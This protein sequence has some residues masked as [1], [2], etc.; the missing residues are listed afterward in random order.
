MPLRNSL[1]FQVR[2]WR[3][4]LKKKWRIVNWIC[5]C[6]PAFFL[7]ACILNFKKNCHDKLSVANEILEIYSGNPYSHPAALPSYSNLGYFIC[8]CRLDLP[9]FVQLKCFSSN[10][11]NC[12][13]L[14]F[15][16]SRRLGNLAEWSSD[17]RS[18]VVKSVNKCFLIFFLSENMNFKFFTQVHLTSLQKESLF[19]VQ[20]TGLRCVLN[21]FPLL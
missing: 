21:V 12:T 1:P 15:F 3:L 2:V 19:L 10:R 13:K 8:I 17:K 18:R 14:N 9:K 4:V 20:I 11:L 6:I 7:V 16:L 5:T